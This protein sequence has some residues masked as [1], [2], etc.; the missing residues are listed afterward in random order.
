MDMEA[1]LS[2]DGHKWP[3]RPQYFIAREEAS[4]RAAF[5]LS[6]NLVVDWCVDVIGNFDLAL[7]QAQ[8]VLDDFRAVRDFIRRSATGASLP[9]ER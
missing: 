3:V 6:D 2:D 4:R 5:E 1:N 8:L 9:R 7:Q